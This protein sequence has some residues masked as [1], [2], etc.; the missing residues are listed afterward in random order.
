MSITH[1]GT[2]TSGADYMVDV[3][4]EVV[5]KDYG[6]PGLWTPEV[7]VT[8]TLDGKATIVFGGDLPDELN[9]HQARSLAALLQEAADEAER[10][11]DEAFA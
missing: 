10:G 3:T 4:R 6:I 9:S 1:Y 5:F 11:P 2:D 7:V 8:E